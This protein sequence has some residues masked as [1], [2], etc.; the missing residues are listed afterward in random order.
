[1]ILSGIIGLLLLPSNVNGCK[2]PRQPFNVDWSLDEQVRRLEIGSKINNYWPLFVNLRFV[3][4]SVID[5][6]V[7]EVFGRTNLLKV[8]YIELLCFKPCHFQMCG[9]R[10]KGFMIINKVDSRNIDA[11][12]M[13]SIIRYKRSNKPFLQQVLSSF[14]I[15]NFKKIKQK[16]NFKI[17]LYLFIIILCYIKTYWFSVNNYL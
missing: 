15:I 3:I 16:T 13:F 11:Y 5:W 10:S 8:L 4:V 14:N 1:M 12:N 17:I 6:S 7:S 9:K 2:I